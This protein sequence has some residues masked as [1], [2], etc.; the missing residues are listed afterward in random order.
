MDITLDRVS[1]TKALLKMSIAPE[2]YQPAVKKKI[3]EYAKNAQ[4]KGFRPG[5]VPPTLI[6]KMYGKSVLSDQ[7]NEIISSTISDYVKDSELNVLGMPKDVSE[8]EPSWNDDDTYNFVF[9]LGTAGD[10][11][12]NLEAAKAV[13]YYKFE[14]DEESKQEA[15]DRL[16]RQAGEYKEVDA[17]TEKSLIRGNIRRDGEILI[18]NTPVSVE[19]VLDEQRDLF[20]GLGNGQVI[21]FDPHKAIDETELPHMFNVPREELSKIEGEYEFEVTSITEF[22]PADFSNEETFNKL[23]EN[24]DKINSLEEL[25]SLIIENLQKAFD[26]DSKDIYH[27]EVKRAL[28][29]NTEIELPI[30]FLK[31]WL[32]KNQRLEEQDQE[33]SDEDFDKFLTDMKWQLIVERFSRDSDYKP[34]EEDMVK[35]AYSRVQSMYGSYLSP[36]TPPELLNSLVKNYLDQNDG[37][38]IRSIRST[39]TEKHVID[40]IKEQLSPEEKTENGNE[41]DVIY[42]RLFPQSQEEEEEITEEAEA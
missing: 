24:D 4:M 14:V 18:E 12:P 26:S 13:S 22:A 10:F 15:K 11:E 36:N 6:K 33:I 21:T 25:E 30:D 28:L 35:E 41:V 29:D 20:K 32:H 34:T 8:E 31:D 27:E 38:N 19:Y 37:Q 2:D 5:K 42:E 23:F 7:I 17:S 40:Q 16:S 1:N 3:K 9:E 39:L